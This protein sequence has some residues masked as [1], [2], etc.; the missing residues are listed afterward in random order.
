MWVLLC[1]TGLRRGEVL[2][3]RWDDG[4]LVA[5]R[6]A[7]QR[8]LVEVSGYDL[9]VSEPKSARGKRSVRL[10]AHTTAELVRHR[11]RQLEERMA[12]GLGSRTE[13]VFTR[14]D[15]SQLQPQRVSRSF[16]SLA[17][18]PP[19]RTS[20][21]PSADP[22]AESRSRP[23]PPGGR[24]RCWPGSADSTR[25]TVRRSEER[26]VGKEGVSTGS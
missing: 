22:P 25:S 6:S 16:Q 17:Q 19:W 15:G 24:S 14:P 13:L 1:S 2:C 7:V 10:D 12:H 5:G 8:A 21:G 26:R 23:P 18:A 4:D 20:P 11:R 9:R 3:L